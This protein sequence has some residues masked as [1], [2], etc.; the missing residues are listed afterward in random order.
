MCR[1]SRIPY[2]QNVYDLLQ[3]EPGESPEAARMIAEHEAAHGPLPAAVREWYSVPDVVLLRPTPDDW[4]DLWNLCPGT[5]WWEFSNED[6][7]EPL[8]DVLTQFV[9]VRNRPEF[10]Y[11]RVLNENQGVVRWWVKVTGS[12]DPPVWCDNDREDDPNE[13]AEVAESFS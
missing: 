13:W 1:T 9:G 11:V 7:A 8:P 6:P 3:L 5:L 2:H 10:P 12:D 4:G